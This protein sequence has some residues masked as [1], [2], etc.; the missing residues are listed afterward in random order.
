MILDVQRVRRAR[1][2][3]GH[4]RR[5]A[6]SVAGISESAWSKMEKGCSVSP[7]TARAAAQTLVVEITDLYPTEK[8]CA[9]ESA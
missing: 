5:S 9:L 2:L 1:E 3:A 8:G 4:T 6:A 7:H